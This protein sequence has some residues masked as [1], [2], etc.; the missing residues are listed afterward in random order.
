MKSDIA[1]S[2]KSIVNPIIVNGEVVGY[3]PLEIPDDT[4]E[5][6]KRA[7]ES[8]IRIKDQQNADKRNK[9]LVDALKGLTEH[10]RELIL[11]N[12]KTLT[13]FVNGGKVVYTGNLQYRSYEAVLDTNDNAYKL[14]LFLAGHP[15]FE[16]SSDELVKHLNP[17]RR[18][19]DG[20]LPERRIRDTI[21][22]IK[23]SLKLNIKEDH[24]FII[25]KGKFG[26]NCNV[27]LKVW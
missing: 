1:T 9:D 15:T 18:N 4:E 16:F 7:R 10:Q 5:I 3:L 11:G 17:S 27:E 14:L 6:I 20:A 8:N 19:A 26:I 21:T 2:D 23:K 24:F 25:N 13:I 22:K 12:L